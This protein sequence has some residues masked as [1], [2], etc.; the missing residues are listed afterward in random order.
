MKKIILIVIIFLVV[1]S[2]NGNKMNNSKNELDNTNNITQENN[3][4]NEIQ[5]DV[6]EGKT[7][8]FIGDS[9]VRGYGNG[10]NGFDYYLAATL[11]K[12]TFI[13]NS[14]SGSTIT[15]NSGSDNIIMINQAKTLNGNPDIIVLDGGANDI[16]GYALGFLNNDLKKEIGKVDM[17]TTISSNDTVITD[18]EK[19]LMCLKEKFPNAKICYLQ[20]FLLDDDTISHLTTETSLKQ[21]IIARRDAFYE[22]IPQ[23]CQKWNMEY[24]D[25][26]VQFPGTETK[27][28]QDDWIHIKDEGYKLITPYL[29][30]KLEEM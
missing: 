24:L 8:A 20:P 21:E 13:N 23:L 16:I 2:L 11:P 19:I 1:F 14:K 28:R 30:K 25:V 18:F 22:E 17:N 9:L 6:L 15:D 27:Y 4:Q 10:D 3:V 7:I 29:L 12:T 26:S 5:E